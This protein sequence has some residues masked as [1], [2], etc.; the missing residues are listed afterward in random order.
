LISR[1]NNFDLIRLLAALQVVVLHGRGHLR[2][3]GTPW[4]DGLRQVLV[5]FPGVPVFFLISGFLIAMSYDNSPD[6]TTFFRKRLLRIYPGLWASLVV[7]LG[8]L[9]AFG[10]VGAAALGRP[11][12]WAWVLGQ[13]SFVQF[14]TPGFLRGFGVGTPNGSLWT[15]TVELQFYLAVP[16]LLGGLGAL[17]GP[18]VRNLVLIGLGVA[19]WLAFVHLEAAPD[20]FANKL[21]GV[22][23]LPY[24]FNFLAGILFYSY[25]PRLYP[26]IR[27][28]GGWWLAGYAACMAVFSGRLQLFGEPFEA[29]LY[30]LAAL[31][32]LAFTVFSV[33]FS[34][35]TLSEKLLRGVDVSYGVYIYHMLVVNTL[36]EVGWTGRVSY[37]ILAILASL[38]LGYLSWTYV[39]KR[40][41]RLK[42]KFIPAHETT[43]SVPQTGE[44]ILAEVPRPQVRKGHVLIRTHRTLVSLGTERMLVEFGKSNLIEKARQQPDKVKM[45]LD[46][47]K[48]RRPAAHAG[49]RIH[50]ARR[51]P[52]A[53]LLQRRPGARSGGGRHRLQAR[54]PGGLQRSPRRIRV[55]AQKPGGPR[56]RQ[57]LV[58]R[59]RLHGDRG[60]WPAGH[61][62][63]RPTLGETVV[64]SG[65]G[66]I[67][68]ITAELLLANGCRVV[69]FDFDAHKVRLAREKGVE[70]FDLSQGTDP[71][72]AVLGLTDGVGA[73]AVLIT[74]SAKG[75]EV[76][77]Q[78]AR[79]SRKRGR[80][81]L[82]GVVGLH[83]NRADFYEKE[84]S[85]QVSCS[86]G[87]GR[88]DDDYEK[89][90]HDYPLPFVR[91][92][93][94]RNFQAVLGPSPRAAS[95]S[96]ASSPRRCP[97]R[98]TAK[99]TATWAAG[100]PLPP[101]SPTRPPPTRPRPCAP[102]PDC[103]PGPG[104]GGEAT[105]AV[106]GAGNF[107]KMTLLPAL[108]G[109]KADIKYIVSASGV[110]GT[111]L[112]KKHGI[113]YSSTAYQDALRDPGVRAGAHHH[114]AQPA[115]RHDGA[116]PG[117]GQARIRGESRW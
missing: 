11:S 40:F 38:T 101:C 70:A 18:A 1:T 20:T 5:Y 16:L 66:L 52:A 47:V 42:K 62:A 10:F 57:R 82:V 109:L 99:F 35:P 78:A 39:E 45:V 65:L 33:A 90:G 25:F 13:V 58:R 7:T 29:N 116:G 76:I 95:T 103:R 98:R 110:S 105:L 67:G 53:G 21:L 56:A 107:T 114:A 32:L 93:E 9:A 113:A 80:I 17:A 87:P 75:D 49:G 104:V 61:P 30:A 111:H 24:F 14:Y 73:D 89:R 115:R 48:D 59:S 64:V 55:R 3:P 69:G 8:L 96:S 27:G 43:H 108:A 68:L 88:Y 51:T 100:V 97:W 41:I 83:L 37:W 23:L 54:R 91:W 79:M 15:I 63:G 6:V 102:A 2:V 117:S 92:T 112:A 71:V 44:T 36:V 22:S 86:Y 12:F 4:L 106:V 46:K 72:Q 26:L 94:N 84:L 60:H 28:K 50:Q 77:T 34:F 19:S 74:A 81:V 85:F 31:V